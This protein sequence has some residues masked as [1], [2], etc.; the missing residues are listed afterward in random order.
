M[1]RTQRR[2]DGTPVRLIF[3]G[4]VPAEGLESSHARATCKHGLLTVRIPRTEEAKRKSRRIIVS[5]D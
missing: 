1:A 3:P 5:V 4:G 2:H